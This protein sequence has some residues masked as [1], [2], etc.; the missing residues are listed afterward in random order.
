MGSLQ[1]GHPI[2]EVLHIYFLSIVGV[3]FCSTFYSISPILAQDS[4]A[5]RYTGLSSLA[6]R[7]CTP[8]LL[9]LDFMDDG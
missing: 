4:P 3:A 5:R 8:Q 2:A 9:L 6:F 7:I 1:I